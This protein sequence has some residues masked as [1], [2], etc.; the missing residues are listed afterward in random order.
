[1]DAPSRWKR[2][3]QPTHRPT[4]TFRVK[5]RV[6]LA[7]WVVLCLILLASIILQSIWSKQKEFER[8][9]GFFAHHVTDRALI[10]ETALEGFSAFVMSRPEFDQVTASDF[11]KNLLV[12]YPFLYMFEVAQKVDHS[13]RSKIEER[14]AEIY[15]GFEIRH[16]AYDGDR[17]WRIAPPADDYYPIVFQ[18]PYFSDEREIVGLDLYSTDILIAAMR[19]SSRLGRPM[20]TQPFNLAEDVLGYVIHRPLDSEINA[21]GRP[22]T[23]PR[24]ALLALRADRLF[25]GL[26][27]NQ[28]GTSIR[29]AYAQTRNHDTSDMALINSVGPSPTKAEALLL[30]SFQHTTALGDFVPSQPFRL[31]QTQQMT[32]SDLNLFLLFLVS[33]FAFAVPILARRFATAYADDKIREMD[34]EGHLYQLANFDSLTGAANR[35]RLLDQLETT[36]LRAT[37]DKDTFCLLFIDIDQFKTLNDGHGHAA[38]DAVLVGFARR[39]M[40]FLRSNEVFGRL[41]GDEFVLI[42]SESHESAVQALIGRVKEKAAE[43]TIYRGQPL[44]IDVSIGYACYPT[45]GRNMNSLLDAAD[46]RMYQEK[47]APKSN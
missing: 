38:G 28:Q 9:T 39:V 1:M 4:V 40:E 14:L 42:A 45:D 34:A 43:P 8:S 16:F 46:K 6:L 2:Q 44:S 5:E 18:E 27:S 21:T 11:A 19:E 35:Y 29:L 37:R 41:G 17:Q 3:L 36:L 15:P 25:G 23:A 47:R 12:R 20:A 13:G 33:L 31:S 24:Y 30:P 22:L 26:R 10:A 32:W 7:G